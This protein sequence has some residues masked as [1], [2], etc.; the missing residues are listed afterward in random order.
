MSVAYILTALIFIVQ[1][2]FEFCC[3]AAFFMAIVPAI[4][5]LFHLIG[6]Y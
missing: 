4:Y 6:V 2:N 5:A 3:S 1:K